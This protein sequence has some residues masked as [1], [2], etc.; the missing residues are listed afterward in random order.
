[1]NR[2]ILVRILILS[3]ALVFQSFVIIL[4][5]AVSNLDKD[6]KVI[7]DL[8]DQ[9]TACFYAGQFDSVIN[10]SSK[11]IEKS[12]S[13]W[14]SPNST[15]LKAYS[16][17]G[18][19]YLYK[20]D[21]V[22][23]EHYLNLNLE[24]GLKLYGSEDPRLVGPLNNLAALYRNQGRFMQAKE[25]YNH[26]LSIIEKQPAEKQTYIAACLSNLASV[27][28][29]LGELSQAETL[30]TRA[31]EIVSEDPE[32]KS[33][34]RVSIINNL[35]S[36]AKT[37]DDYERA[38]SYYRKA[39]EIC[40]K[41]MGNKRQIIAL[42]YSNL[43]EVLYFGNKYKDAE[44]SFQKALSIRE[45]LLGEK[46][47]D[48][49]LCH[50]KLAEIFVAAGRYP[51][52]LDHF[53][54]SQKSKENFINYVFT[55]ASEEQK[56]RYVENYPYI[57]D[58]LLSFAQIDRSYQ[59]KALALE[60]LFEG[61]GLVLEASLSTRKAA[62]FTSDK[63]SLIKLE[64]LRQLGENIADLILSGSATM[65]SD[66]YRD[67]LEI[68][69]HLKER[70][71]AELG[72]EVSQFSDFTAL[73][74]TRIDDAARALPE[75]SVL[76]EIVKYHPVDFSDYSERNEGDSARY[77]LFQLSPAREIAI[78]DL[79]D[80]RR[81]EHLIAAYQ[82]ELLSTQHTIIKHSES[83]AI[84]RLN[85]ITDRLYK[86]LFAPIESTL[87]NINRIFI[88]PDAA[89]NLIPY[90]ILTTPDN[91]YI[92]EKYEIDYL[93]SGR[94]MLEF[95]RDKA[96][97][98]NQA[99]LIADPDFDAELAASEKRDKSSM[100]NK[101]VLLL[102]KHNHQPLA[103]T[104][105]QKPFGRVFSTYRECQSVEEIFLESGAFNPMLYRGAEASEGI[106]RNFSEPPAVLHIATHAYFCTNAANKQE[107]AMRENPLI[108]SGLLFRGANRSIMQ[109]A[110][111][112]SQ[113]RPVSEDGILTSLEVSGLNLMGTELVV[114][115]ACQTG[116]G[117]VVGGEG[118]F[119]FR[120]A[121]Q[122]TGV[123]SLIM[124]MWDIPDHE[125]V[126][127]IE[128]F[129]QFWISGD[130]KAN[131]LRKASLEMLNN[132]RRNNANRHPLFWGGF[133]LIGNPK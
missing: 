113:R 31:L 13:E 104:C 110:D 83:E 60:M 3:I 95:G 24:T 64:H 114:L 38:E 7:A 33:S 126:N 68:L 34:D 100:E 49:A 29:N 124:S 73:R 78:F 102:N 6:T 66:R 52:A 27:H 54:M 82:Q 87:N 103:G 28:R 116:L 17:L 59:V 20:G 86:L 45:E 71:E 32:A 5:D 42:I 76:W 12:K 62:Y 9:A 97:S 131:A 16:L 119:G 129:Y 111:S 101:G 2:R 127:L 25:L 105:L 61:K 74:G 48:V 118:V 19:S 90:Q 72:L 53:I 117:K 50:D 109:T 55:Y 15:M 39:L 14:E 130:T 63:S 36:I 67:S 35:G 8:L 10:L 77:L 41:E 4:S 26:A 22:N 23:A 56:L 98:G 81:I 128:K 108:Y 123:N 88:S 43:G 120:R 46:H 44:R 89:L 70:E 11:A 96:V 106:L 57:N 121:F 125:T 75:N 69:T 37:L 51:R 99:V 65:Q 92:I 84:Q 112:N 40:E 1:M 132:G 21:N 18:A 80:A 91:K 79:G 94:D 58:A 47:P 30:Y 93:L 122:H 107:L 85:D 115:S 133:I